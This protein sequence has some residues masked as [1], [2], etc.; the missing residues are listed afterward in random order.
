MPD[1]KIVTVDQWN[2]RVNSNIVFPTYAYPIARQL[3]KQLEFAPADLPDIKLTYYKYPDDAEW[4][5]NIVNDREVYDPVASTQ[6][7]W[8]EPV[9][10]E[11]VYLICSY[12]GMNLQHY[13]LD[14]YSKG[15]TQTEV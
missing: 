8:D 14:Q 11:I 7:E 10:N 5:G 12:L 9:F 1:V 2:K 4:V 13:E 3:N 15:T 6:L